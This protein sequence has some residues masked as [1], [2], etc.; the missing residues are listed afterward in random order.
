M[1]NIDNAKDRVVVMPVYNS[2]VY[3]DSYSKTSGSL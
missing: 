1:Y 3:K 2:I